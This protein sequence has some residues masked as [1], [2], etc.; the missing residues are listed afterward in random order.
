[1][2]FNYSPKIVTDGLVFAVDA[3]NKK[4]Y[5]GSGTTWTDLAGNNNGTLTNG[6]TFDSGNGG[7]ITLDGVD[8]YISLPSGVL[9]SNTNVTISV[10]LKNNY[11]TTTDNKGIF[12]INGSPKLYLYMANPGSGG[13]DS[14]VTVYNGSLYAAPAVGE[15]TFPIGETHNFSLVVDGSG[16]FKYYKDGALEASVTGIS[17]SSSGD[18]YLGVYPTL[19]NDGQFT[20]YSVKIYNRALTS[21]EISQNHNAL[22][23]RFG[24]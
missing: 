8:D 17:F 14:R 23:S 15:N 10:I 11:S 12:G 1:M 2:A 16:N 6:P 4:S 20:F 5:P 13:T 24:L 19:T 3:A 21:A 7:G 22:K 18:T 9:P